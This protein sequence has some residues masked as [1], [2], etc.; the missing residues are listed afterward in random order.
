M[1]TD[2]KGPG[3]A[4]MMPLKVQPQQSTEP[5]VRRPQL[6][7]VP[8]AIEVK[9]PGGGWKSAKEAFAPADGDAVGPERTGVVAAGA[10]RNEWSRRSDIASAPALQRAVGTDCAGVAVADAE[11]RESAFRRISGRAPALHRAIGTQAAGAVAAS[12]N[13]CE[14]AERRFGLAVPVAAPAADQAVGAERAGVVFAGGDVDPLVGRL[15]AKGP[16]E[17]QAHVVAVIRAAGGFGRW[18]FAEGALI[19][20]DVVGVAQVALDDVV[21]IHAGSR[22]RGGLANGA[23]CDIESPGEDA[24]DVFAVVGPAGVL[25]VGVVGAL[26]DADVAVVAEVGFDDVVEFDAASGPLGRGRPGRNQRRGHRHENDDGVEGEKT[27]AAGT[28]GLGDF[29]GAG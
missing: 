21:E 9:V 1:L 25:A 23:R 16:A 22:P 14:G 12:G 24:S 7:L 27:P 15:D 5:S 19:N 11:R 13:L 20:A 4:V 29:H 17:E 10:Y 6:T 26:V 28:A 18:T 2:V 8:E 3:G